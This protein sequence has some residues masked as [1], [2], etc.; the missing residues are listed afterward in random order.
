M[1]VD[2]LSTSNSVSFNIK[3]AETFGL[4]TAIYI[5]ELTNIY[6]KAIRK[7]KIEEYGGSVYFTI[8]RKYLESRTTFDLVE[9]ERIERQL[10]ELKLIN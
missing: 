5:S 7:K 1:L 6:E 10:L 9:Q 8:D 4:H 3:V 2:L